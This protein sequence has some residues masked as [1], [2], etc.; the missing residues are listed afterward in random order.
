[1]IKF[2]SA[3]AIGVVIISFCI[4]ISI[5][6]INEEDREVKEMLGRKIVLGKDTLLIVDYSTFFQSY[7]LQNDMSI[8]FDLARKFQIK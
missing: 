4:T 1:M 2:L 3:L 8:S 5:Q 6:A 7:K